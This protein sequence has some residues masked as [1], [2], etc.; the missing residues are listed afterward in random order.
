MCFP[1]PSFVFSVHNLSERQICGTVAN[2]N[3]LVCL[4][5]FL[6]VIFSYLFVFACFFFFSKFLFFCFILMCFWTF[7]FLSSRSWLFF[8]L[9]LPFYVSLFHE[10]SVW[11][12]HRFSFLFFSPFTYS[13]F[14]HRTPCFLNCFRSHGLFFFF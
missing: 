7:F 10:D 9:S 6:L 11:F 3:K 1:F 8:P 12:D 2:L 5:P 14:F 13:P 4:F